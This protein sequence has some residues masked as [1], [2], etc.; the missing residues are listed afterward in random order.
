M[1]TC[2][3]LSS[4]C[5]LQL[6]ITTS[7]LNLSWVAALCFKVWVCDALGVQCYCHRM[8]TQV[9]IFFLWRVCKFPNADYITTFLLW[10]L[11]CTFCISFGRLEMFVCHFWM[12]FHCIIQTKMSVYVIKHSTVKASSVYLLWHSSLSVQSVI[13]SVTWTCLC[14]RVWWRTGRGETGVVVLDSGL[15][16]QGRV[17]SPCS[18]T[19]E[20]CLNKALP[21]SRAWNK[22]LK[23]IRQV[24]L[25]TVHLLFCVAVQKSYQTTMKRKYLT[26]N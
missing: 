7:S 26:L 23:R 17:G 16:T 22:H 12:S 14:V 13:Y 6:N 11:F 10:L 18:R 4:K 19:A 25:I 2:I 20:I 9:F 21:S 8:H 5:L 24:T 1:V 3:P 15:K